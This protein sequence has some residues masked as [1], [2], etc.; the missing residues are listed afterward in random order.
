M[1]LWMG[2]GKTGSLTDL[3]EVSQQLGRPGCRLQARA[4]LVHPLHA[5]AGLGGSHGNQGGVLAA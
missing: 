3:R 5:L 1:L 2:E 4:G